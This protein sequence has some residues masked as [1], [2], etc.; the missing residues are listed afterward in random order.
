[1]HDTRLPAEPE[2]HQIRFK[3]KEFTIRL[4]GEVIRTTIKKLAKR[5]GEA[6][7]YESGI[8]ITEA[9]GESEKLLKDLIADFVLRSINERRTKSAM[10]SLSSFSDSPTSS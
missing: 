8:R 4:R 5:P 10:R 3:W 6:S 7:L 9:V 1:M 2:T